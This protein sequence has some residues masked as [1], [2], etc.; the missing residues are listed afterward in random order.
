MAGG[1]YSPALPIYRV[2]AG[3]SAGTCCPSALQAE[4]AAPQKVLT[5]T[6]SLDFLTSALVPPKAPEAVQ[7]LSTETLRPDW[8]GLGLIVEVWR[9]SGNLEDSQHVSELGLPRQAHC[10]T[11]DIKV[12]TQVLGHHGLFLLLS[13]Y[14]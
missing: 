8:E 6:P 7:A 12:V 4:L 10:V 11:P 3:S 9:S 2:Q 13:N 1:S 14:L 5:M